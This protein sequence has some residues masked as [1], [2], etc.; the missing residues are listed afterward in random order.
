MGI[1]KN[2]SHKRFLSWKQFKPHNVILSNSKKDVKQ[3]NFN[4][5]N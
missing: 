4:I 2:I 5:L 1:K 3:I